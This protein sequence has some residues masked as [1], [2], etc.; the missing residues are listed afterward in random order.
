MTERIEDVPAGPASPIVPKVYAAISS[1][2]AEMAKEGIAKTSKN[3]QQGYNFRGIDAVYNAL[4]PILAKHKLCILPRILKREVV[5]RESAQN[6]ALFY[7]TVEADFD[8][9]GCRRWL[10][11]YGQN[12]RRSNGLWRQGYQQSHERR[13]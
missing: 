3:Q 13:L 11:S 1:V 6:K 4:S 2:Q 12:V 10:A 5:E 7:V 9:R 8:F